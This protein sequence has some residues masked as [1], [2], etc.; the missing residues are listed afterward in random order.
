MGR[1]RRKVGKY[2][3]EVS[4]NEINRD[5][6]F[7]YSVYFIS[8]DSVYIDGSELSLDMA[9]TFRYSNNEEEVR[10]AL[11]M[12]IENLKFRITRTEQIL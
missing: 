4:S 7:K 8:E 6:F 9:S 1:I 10:Q 5:N 2:T 12:Y 3:I 11:K